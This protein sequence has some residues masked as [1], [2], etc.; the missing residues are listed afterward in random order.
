MEAHERELARKKA[1]SQHKVVTKMN[2]R[3]T[4]SLKYSIGSSSSL[5]G[6]A[7]SSVNILSRRSSDSFDSNDLGHIISSPG[8]DGHLPQV[9]EF[10]EEVAK[11]RAS[12]GK[13]I[14]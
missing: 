3:G 4:E 14:S 5:G 8:R 10:Q 7:N 1:P 2:L 9:T 12:R 11:Q 13:Q 6:G